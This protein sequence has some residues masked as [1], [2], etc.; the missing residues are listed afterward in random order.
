MQLRSNAVVLRLEFPAESERAHK[1][2]Y[3]QVSY[4]VE[5]LRSCQILV[6]AR[7]VST[8]FFSPRSGPDARDENSPRM[9]QTP[10]LPLPAA[11][12]KA[13]RQKNDKTTDTLHHTHDSETCIPKRSPRPP[14]PDRP[15]PRPPWQRSFPATY[16]TP[17]ARF[18]RDPEA[19]DAVFPCRS[20]LQ[21]HVTQLCTPNSSPRI[22]APG[23]SS[24]SSL[25]S[26]FWDS[27]V[28]TFHN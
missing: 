20:Q 3:C 25:H 16:L 2:N 17:D 24:T 11:T 26:G 19:R 14:D 27:S 5:G 23:V 28:Q 6:R 15:N 9:T 7:T 4:P 12:P 21:N 13:T 18:Y 10:E 22:T 8:K 1:H